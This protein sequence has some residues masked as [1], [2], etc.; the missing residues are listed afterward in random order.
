MEPSGAIGIDGGGTW[1]KAGFCSEKN[2]VIAYAKVASG[3][4]EGREAYAVSLRKALK[5]LEEK[6]ADH[7]VKRTPVGLSL[8][9]LMTRNRRDVVVM[10]NVKGMDG[11]SEPMS[12]SELVGQDLSERVVAAENDAGCAAW[13]EWQNAGADPDRRLLLV[14]WGT[15]LGTAL[16]ADGEIQYG[17]EGG[18]MPIRTTTVGADWE[19]QAAVPAI[20]KRV[21]HRQGKAD[22]SNPQEAA[23]NILRQAEAGDEV[24]RSEVLAAVDWL[25]WGIQVLASVACPDEILIG[26]AFMANG[27]ILSQVQEAVIKYNSPI[28]SFRMER[29]NVQA[30][31][32][33]NQA[34]IV[35]AADLARRACRAA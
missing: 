9:G 4:S 5:Q 10:S 30:A 27:W 21:A 33:G 34:G 26:G 31:R 20:V 16:I 32:L 11:L 24:C 18:H 19:S 29:E 22:I 13:A 12:L 14:T 7:L 15:G 6:V 3:A 2:E 35:G 8:P 23:K 17:W 1:I 25:G 28:K